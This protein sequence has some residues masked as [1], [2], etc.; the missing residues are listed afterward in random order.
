[1]VYKKAYKTDLQ[2]DYWM[3]T[4][5]YRT[6][7]LISPEQEAAIRLAV[8][9]FNQGRTWGLTLR[10]D[11]HDGHLICGM[12]PIDVPDGDPAAGKEAK[13]PGAYEARCLL[14]GLCG[15]SRECKVDWEVHQ[16]YGLRP[17]GYIRTG[18]C[19]DDP[20]ASAEAGRNMCEVLPQRSSTGDRATGQPGARL[21]RE[22]HP[23]VAR[24][25]GGN[26]KS[27]PRQAQAPIGNASTGRSAVPA[28]PN[29]KT[30]VGRSLPEAKALLARLY[31]FEFP[32]SLF[33][34]HEFLSS[35][36][37]GELEGYLDALGMKTIGPLQVLSLTETELDTLKS[38]LPLVLHWRFI[39][40]LPEFFSCLFGDGDQLHWGL[41]L[42]EPDKGFRGVA[43]FCHNDARPISVYPSLFGAVLQRIERKIASYQSIAEDREAEP[44]DKANYRTKLDDLYRFSEKFHRFIKASHI[45]LDD[46][47][48]MGLPSETGLSLLTADRGK[49]WFS[50]ILDWYSRWP[51]SDW[52]IFPRTG[53]PRVVHLGKMKDASEMDQLI[54]DAVSASEEGRALPVL[55]LGRSLWYYFDCIRFF[56]GVRGVQSR[57]YKPI[58]YDLLK[59]AYTLLDRPALLRVLDIHFAHRDLES[60]DLLNTH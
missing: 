27:P 14:N 45:P 21:D 44:E 55:S 15:I 19:H 41:L 54:L 60:V 35:L 59:R 28:K 40:D 37:E 48:G 20:E 22:R 2:E 9:S 33:L 51:R 16:T 34:L 46:G 47:R 57:D 36:G 18:E 56:Y 24:H 12:K 30:Q 31:G 3:A 26:Y 38:A 50:S 43:S 42:D 49:G 4:L 32:D 8:D 52:S 6:C 23:G 58:A 25:D 11:E 10:R 17:V 53:H 29:E 7:Q 5:T 1:V 39:R 13:W